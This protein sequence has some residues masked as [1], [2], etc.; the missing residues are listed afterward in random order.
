M[1]GDGRGR[2]V[3]QLSG[4]PK[5]SSTTEARSRLNSSSSL[6]SPSPSP[7]TAP[8]VAAASQPLFL[9]NGARSN[10]STAAGGGGA[11][12][13]AGSVKRKQP[14]S[15]LRLNSTAGAVAAAAIAEEQGRGRFPKLEEIA[16][17]DYEAIVSAGGEEQAVDGQRRLKR[18]SMSFSNTGTGRAADLQADAL[19]EWFMVKGDDVQV[20]D[21]GDSS[22]EEEEDRR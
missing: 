5:E 4:L 21:T 13:G 1:S 16:A 14:S 8:P 18:G 12:A 7:Y 22:K 11:G 3:L 2:P 20:R 6:S 19:R 9:H 17:P 15:R 10:N